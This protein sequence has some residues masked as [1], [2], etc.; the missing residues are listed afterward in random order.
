MLGGG[1]SSA[2]FK[3]GG[4]NSTSAH[5]WR[6]RRPGVTAWPSDSAR[7]LMN[8]RHNEGDDRGHTHCHVG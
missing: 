5:S 2:G 6:R 1:R 8:R 3:G 7:C 4:S